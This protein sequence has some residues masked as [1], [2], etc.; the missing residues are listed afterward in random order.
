MTSA[1]PV[2]LVAID[3][4]GTLLTT[5]HR[6]TP[7]VAAALARVRA[8][9]VTV[10]LTTSR[11]PRAVWPILFE[12]GMVEPEVFIASQGALTGSYTES[13][14]LWVTDRQ[15][16]PVGPARAVCAAGA[17]AGLAV[18]WF[19]GE[20]W[21]VPVVDDRIRQEAA[22]V[23]C[24]PQVA[25]L[26]V[27]TEAPD[28]ILLLGPPTTPGSDLAG[29]VAVPVGLVGFASTPTHL[30]ITR[31]DVGKSAALVRLCSHLGVRPAEVAAIGD[32]RNDLGMLS[33][34]GVSVAPANA[35]PDV[36][37]AA[38][39]ITSSNDDDGVAH[40]LDQLVP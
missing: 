34:A 26:S 13:G 17:S 36:L 12:L 37:A 15:P 29:T 4:D 40:A 20:R 8:R 7:T 23:G 5:D 24:F 33:V 27:A 38:D 2:R 35:H 16:M 18:S 19:A 32:G 14:E 10:V 1:T 21:L 39:V 9:G 28:K 31:S 22:V 11:P 30:E 25:D 6:I 3:V